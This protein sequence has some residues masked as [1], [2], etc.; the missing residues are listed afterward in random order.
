MSAKDELADLL[1]GG[2]QTDIFKAE[3]A[4]RL[5]EAIG[6]NAE[7]VNKSSYSPVLGKLQAY[8]VEVFVLSITRL[9]DV[10]KA[11]YPLRSLPG[12]LDY[13]HEHA[14]DVPVRE[15]G[16]LE[17]SL[18]SLGA[19]SDSLRQM[20]EPARTKHIS[21]LLRNLLPD[22]RTNPALHALRALR[23]KQLAHAEHV[24]ATSLP[25]TTWEPAAQLLEIARLTLGALGAYTST[26]YFADNGDYFLSYDSHVA[27]TSAR[28]LLRHLGIAKPLRE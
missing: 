21:A 1:R 15:L 16:F 4:L 3:E 18:T 27:A 13:L 11:R 19:W 5:S 22:P 17:Q 6:E 14:D 25:R 28:R 23:D 12:V 10:P 8:A 26:A 2:P 20:P 24:D 9:F 7:G